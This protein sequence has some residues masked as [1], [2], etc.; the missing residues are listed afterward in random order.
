M[1]TRCF[2]P[3]GIKYSFEATNNKRLQGIL[4]LNT[5]DLAKYIMSDGDR[6][7]RTVY[8]M[9]GD[10]HEAEDVTQEVFLKAHQSL[11]EFRGESSLGTWI[12]G[13]AYNVTKDYIRRKTRRRVRSMTEEQNS[14]LDSAF[15]ELDVEGCCENIMLKESI[16]R[17][18]QVLSE[19]HRAVLVMRE[20]NEMSYSEISKALGV[21]VGTV[22]SRLFRAREKLKAVLAPLYSEGD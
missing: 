12:H 9:L 19:S 2:I 14:A 11:P 10:L 18:L 17:A 20:V 13:V 15:S 1:F 3:D 8:S 5:D 6:I 16:A 22:E 4:F 7:F 21:S